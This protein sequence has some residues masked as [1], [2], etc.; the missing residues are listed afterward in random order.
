MPGKGNA[1]NNSNPPFFFMWSDD[2]DYT[3]IAFTRGRTTNPNGPTAVFNGTGLSSNNWSNFGNSGGLM[4]RDPNAKN[5]TL[6]GGGTGQSGNP[7]TFTWLN[8]Y[9]V[10]RTGWDGIPAQ[11]DNPRIATNGDDIHVS[12][13]DNKDHT[14]KYWYKPSG[15]GNPDNGGN[16]FTGSVANNAAL[17]NYIAAGTT[18]DPGGALVNNVPHRSWVNLDGGIDKETASGTTYTGTD[19]LDPQV[20]GAKPGGYPTGTN[21]YSHFGGEYEVGLSRADA[22][23]RYNAIDVTKGG[24]PVVAYFDETNQTLRLAYY[25]PLNAADKNYWIADRWRVQNVL[26]SGDPNY[27]K[28]GWYVSMRINRNDDR[29]HLAFFNYQSNAL[30]YVSG[31]RGGDGKYSFGTSVTVDNVSSVGRWTDISLD[32]AGRPHISYLDNYRA[33]FHDGLK[34]AFKKNASDWGSADDWE[35]MNVPAIFPALETR[36]SIENYPLPH[37]SS[38][39]LRHWTAA[40]GYASDDYYRVAYYIKQDQN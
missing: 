17:N 2:F 38:G 6:W 21:F 19:P 10:E 22:A 16:N 34:M 11:F 37:Y 9:N 13:Y 4:V 30:V 39:T 25:S 3:D 5:H 31:T 15:N 40:I 24:Y 36:T 23:G 1:V 32:A 35:Y 27:Y 33:G 20:L 26:A 29:L 12:Y 7:P 8:H 14:V 18:N 28:S